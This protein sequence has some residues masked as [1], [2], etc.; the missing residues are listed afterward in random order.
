MRECMQVD[1]VFTNQQRVAGSS[2]LMYKK[3][4]QS[5]EAKRKR[6]ENHTV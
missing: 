3:G 1:K 5:A 6:K 4:K 2:V